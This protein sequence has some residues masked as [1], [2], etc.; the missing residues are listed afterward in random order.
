MILS[1]FSLVYS[2]ILQKNIL[3]DEQTTDRSNY[4]NTG[5][6]TTTLNSHNVDYFF[7][8]RDKK[9]LRYLI[10]KKLLNK[11]WVEFDVA[12]KSI[13][14][15]QFIKYSKMA[16]EYVEYKK[17]LFAEG[18]NLEPYTVPTKTEGCNKEGS[19]NIK[20]ENDD[21]KLHGTKKDAN[22]EEL[23]EIELTK[24]FSTVGSEKSKEPT[25]SQIRK[26]R[27]RVRN[28]L[29]RERRKSRK[30]KKKN[31]QIDITKYINIRL[32]R[33]DIDLSFIVNTI[34]SSLLKV[35][36]KR[37]ITLDKI[38]EL[39]EKSKKYELY[40]CIVFFLENYENTNKILDQLDGV[41]KKIEH[42][43][44][45]PIFDY[46]QCFDIVRIIKN[47]QHVLKHSYTK[48]CDYVLFSA[49]ECGNIERDT[50]FN[51]KL[52]SSI[53]KNILGLAK[54]LEDIVLKKKCEL[55]TFSSV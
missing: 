32:R 42:D 5:T 44:S 46:Q 13:V 28:R 55:F 10:Q 41:V 43:K 11:D 6:N 33:L 16:N 47:N 3:S 52:Y 9:S 39:K 26:I 14:N 49:G 21:S 2:S 30:Y 4:S 18:S 45:K 25:D 12:Y 19:D 36:K 48:N 17:P 27:K 37:Q 34:S 54:L 40:D 51:F 8:D 20:K 24:E 15:H 50:F 38:K 29:K 31:E 35:L 53:V 1:F 22:F 7:A 23:V